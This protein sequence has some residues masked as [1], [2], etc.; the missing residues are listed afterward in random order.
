MPAHCPAGPGVGLSVRIPS[1]SSASLM[2][3]PRCLR[4]RLMG[5]CDWW[6]SPA[7]TDA[8]AVTVACSCVCLLGQ[9]QR[10]AYLEAEAEASG[11][12]AGDREEQ[13]GDGVS[14]FAARMRA[15]AQAKRKALGPEPLPKVCTA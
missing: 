9:V 13:D 4:L 11:G 14:N 2:R 5:P 10:E 1:R 7:V 6:P 15:S 3:F 12:D 8:S